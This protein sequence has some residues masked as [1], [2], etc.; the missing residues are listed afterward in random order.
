MA[1]VEVVTDPGKQRV[2]DPDAAIAGTAL[3]PNDDS[4]WTEV[5]LSAAGMN[6]VRLKH[7]TDWLASRGSATGTSVLSWSSYAAAG[8]FLTVQSDPPTEAKPE[9]H[10]VT[11]SLFIR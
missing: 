3:S 10:P 11:A 1:A 4:A 8:S 7:A 9:S 6:A 2:P 5:P